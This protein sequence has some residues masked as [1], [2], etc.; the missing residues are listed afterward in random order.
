MSSIFKPTW[1]CI[2]QHNQ[3]G[4]KYFCKTTRT[5]PS[6]YNGSGKYWKKHLAIHGTDISTLWYCLFL[7][8]DE[9]VKFAL[10]CSTQWNIV[11]ERDSHGKKTWANEILENGLSGGSPPGRIR[12]LEA[13]KKQSMTSKG[14]KKR[15]TE[16]Y[17]Q[18]KS[19]EHR[20]K[21]SLC[22]LGKKKVETHTDEVKRRLSLNSKGRKWWN[23]SSTEV[24]SWEQ[25]EGFIRGRLP[26]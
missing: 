3:T 6:V 13:R 19:A 24:L 8:K 18:P 21:L 23:N 12:S 11:G 22:Q 20:R 15:N 9:L 7:D 25:P 2:K 1:L 5:D 10:M 14:H 16:K 17:K 4:L 26:R